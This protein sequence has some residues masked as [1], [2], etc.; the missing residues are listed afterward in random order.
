MMHFKFVLIGGVGSGKT[1]QLLT[2][3]GRKFAYLF[4]PASMST[5]YGCPDLETVE[6][7]PGAAD[8]R[9]HARSTITSGSR[10]RDSATALKPVL[11]EN[12]VNDF[13]K[14]EAK[15]F[16][17]DID[18]LMIDSVTLLGV[19]CLNRVYYLQEQTGRADER[20]DYRL[21]G[22]AISDLLSVICSLPCHVILTL[23][24]EW[25]KKDGETE[26]TEKLTVPGSAS[27]RLPRLVSAI[28]YT[29]RVFD[30]KRGEYDYFIITKGPSRRYPSL[31]TPRIFADVDAK[32]DVNIP[33]FKD[34]PYTKKGLGHLLE[35]I[36]GT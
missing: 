13:N 29:E 23:H 15:G 33:T 18:V 30:T 27:L 24:S 9:G 2:M 14:R 26:T 3:P 31:R 36:H 7:F 12:F 25:R 19:A 32:L 4:D 10:L 8:A 16:F 6:F 35:K 5:L 28:W 34:L 20:I 22:E 1:T 21:A 11:Y 17:H